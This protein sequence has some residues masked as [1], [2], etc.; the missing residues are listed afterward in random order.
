MAFRKGGSAR[1]ILG[2]RNRFGYG[3]AAYARIDVTYT[4]EPVKA[5]FQCMLRPLGQYEGENDPPASH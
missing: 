3:F 5:P 2:H 1:F 4:D